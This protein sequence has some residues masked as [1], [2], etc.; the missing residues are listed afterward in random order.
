MKNNNLCGKI[1]FCNCNGNVHPLYFIR[2]H[3]I[4]VLHQLHLCFFKCLS[5][6]Y[7]FISVV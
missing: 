2:A 5:M 6:Y 3:S 7:V 4:T 1:H